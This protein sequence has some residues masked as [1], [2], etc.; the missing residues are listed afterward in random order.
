MR[1]FLMFYMHVVKGVSQIHLIVKQKLID[2]S[3][4]FG[5]MLVPLLFS[6]LEVLLKWTLLW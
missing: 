6:A 2:L 1:M 3:T 4:V 5:L